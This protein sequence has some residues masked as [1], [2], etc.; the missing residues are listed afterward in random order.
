MPK[1]LPLSRLYTQRVPSQL[2]SPSPI[3]VVILSPSTQFHDSIP[4][5]RGP[6]MEVVSVAAVDSDLQVA[7]CDLALRQRHWAIVP[8]YS[9]DT[10]TFST[11]Q[12]SDL[13]WRAWFK[14]S[15]GYQSGPGKGQ[16][17]L[18]MSQITCN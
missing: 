14:M 18:R 7:N 8:G 15:L 4:S 10:P 16:G 9:Q 12:T 1:P 13:S 6:T 17:G 2:F 11:T 3:V 5:T